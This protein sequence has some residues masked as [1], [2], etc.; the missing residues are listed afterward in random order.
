MIPPASDGTRVGLEDRDWFRR[1][2]SET[3]WREIERSAGGGVPPKDDRG[4]IALGLI[5]AVCISGVLTLAGSRGF[6]PDISLP[7]ASRDASQS[8]AIRLSDTPGLDATGKQGSRWCVPTPTA[9]NV[10]AVTRAGETGREALARA[11][12]RG[13]LTVSP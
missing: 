1:E 4:R 6:L 2:S 10:C 12:R 11:L 3:Y 5:A 13:G 8:G 9:G 7:I